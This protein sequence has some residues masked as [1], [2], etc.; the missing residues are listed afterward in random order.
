MTQDRNKLSTLFASLL[1]VAFLLVLASIIWATDRSLGLTDEGLYLLAAR[2]PEEIAQNVSAVYSYTGFLFRIVGYD[3]ASFRVLGL[4]LIVLSAVIFWL[5]YCKFSFAYFKVSSEIQNFRWLSFL[6]IALGGTL[7]YQWSLATPSYY[8]LTAVAVSS[9]AG[10]TLFALGGLS[11]AKYAANAYLAFLFSGLSIGAAFF[12]KFPA[13]ASLFLITSALVV[14][15]RPSPARERFA[16]LLA[17]I[18]GFGL[19]VLLHFIFV[20]SAETTSAMFRAGWNLYQTLGAHDPKAKILAYPMNV[21]VFTYSALGIYWPS[22]LLLISFYIWH[23]LNRRTFDRIFPSVRIPV[24]IIFFVAVLLSVKAGV[25]ISAAERYQPG[26]FGMTSFYL[27]FYLAWILLLL[28]TQLFVSRVTASGATPVAFVKFEYCAALFFLLLVPFT[29]SVG[30]SNPLYN[31]ISFYSPPWF[32]IILFLLTT[33]MLN[34]RFSSNLFAAAL[35][36]IGAFTAS[37][38]IQG[39]IFAPSLLQPVTANLLDQTVPTKVGFPSQEIKLAPELHQVIEELR[40]MAATAGFRPGDDIIAVSYMPGLVFALGARSPGHPAFL[41]WSEK[42]LNY[43]KVALQF[44]DKAR[45]R[46][47]LLL[48]NK[49]LTE[50]ALAKLL[51]SGDLDYPARYEKVGMVAGLSNEYTLYKPIDQA[52]TALSSEP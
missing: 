45:R 18:A 42:Y 43:S 30:T 34:L 52:P 41:L 36:V 1:T 2:Y 47:A 39:S 49:D 28:A 20:Q 24:T 37:N 48:V 25:F 10:F 35:L 13:G 11:T 26:S 50:D 27:A 46:K 32:G 6:F 8:T 9:A 40:A 3:V 21:L 16:S 22:Y 31:V 7:H 12:I 38:T 17:V 15:W 44:S 14:F 4:L 33:L 19:W 23:K 5:G 51:N 29:A